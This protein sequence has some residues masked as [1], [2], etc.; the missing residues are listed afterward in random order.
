LESIVPQA[1]LPENPEI[2]GVWSCLLPG[3][4]LKFGS[5]G[6]KRNTELM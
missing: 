1:Q 5:F 2:T 6:D 4:A 3:G